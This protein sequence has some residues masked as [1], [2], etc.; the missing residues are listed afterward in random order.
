MR[1]S[2]LLAAQCA[3]RRDVNLLANADGARPRSSGDAPRARLTSEPLAAQ[4]ARRKDVN[5]R[6][7]AAGRSEIAIRGHGGQAQRQHER[8]ERTADQRRAKL[9]IDPHACQA[10]YAAD[11]CEIWRV[12][13]TH[14]GQ[15][16]NWRR[17]ARAV[18]ACPQKKGMFERKIGGAVR[19]P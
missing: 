18:S 17:N 14:C 4:G 5:L 2:C 13:A 16:T 9:H 3:R 8:N 12:R 7:R 15:L 1:N 19:L 6:G 11:D 10:I